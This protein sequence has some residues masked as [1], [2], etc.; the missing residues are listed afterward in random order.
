VNVQVIEGEV[1]AVPP[2]DPIEAQRQIAAE[3]LATRQAGAIRR[4][5]GAFGG[6]GD[7]VG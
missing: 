6:G 3:R 5:G 2:H 4:G 1:A 7:D